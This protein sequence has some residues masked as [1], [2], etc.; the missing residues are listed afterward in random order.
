M[1]ADIKG[2]LIPV[3]NGWDNSISP[4]KINNLQAKE[5]NNYEQKAKKS[6]G[7]RESESQQ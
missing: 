6:T 5:I 3:N 7:K 4:N 1:Q 2:K